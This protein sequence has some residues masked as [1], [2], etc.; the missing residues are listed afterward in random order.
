MPLYVEAI[1]S[2]SQ[3]IRRAAAYGYR[4][5]L[6]DVHPNVAQG[7]DD[8]ASKALKQE[9]EA[10]AVTLRQY[11]LVAMWLNAALFAE[12]KSLP[13][14]NGV[15]PRRGAALCMRS[16]EKL[17][18]PE[19]FELLV[20]AFLISREQQTRI[21][22]LKLVQGVGLQRFLVKPKG[23]RKGWGPEVYEEAYEA[24]ELWLEKQCDYDFE[25]V[26]TRSL[27]HKGGRGTGP[28]DPD[29]CYVWQQVLLKG[30]PAWWSLA[31]RQLYYCG[32]PWI[33][34]SVFRADGEDNKKRRDI[35]LKWYR[36]R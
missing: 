33:P 24:L 31:A 35:L 2:P 27:A 26:L 22:L 9:M 36:L 8:E 4:E 34:L 12:G 10:V 18:G 30:D 1:Q 29:S 25:Q 5:F 21:A 15:V 16:V 13:G 3:N 7:V 23:P 17:F 32:S 19:D 28:M 6:A 11:P 14:F 20:G